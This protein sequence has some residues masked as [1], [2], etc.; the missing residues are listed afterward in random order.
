MI[1]MLK[2]RIIAIGRL[3]SKPIGELAG[4]Y[5]SRLT[6]YFPLERI[7]VKDEAAALKMIEDVDR[8]VVCDE[9]GQQRT[10]VELANWLATYERRRTKRLV[11]F[12]GG[13]EG[14]GP[15]VKKRADSLLALSK[16]TFPHEMSQAIL[17]EQL[18]RAATILKGEAYHK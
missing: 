13:P 14:V 4:D 2:I 11:F 3:K 17:L 10:S 6:H 9:R 1:F 18:Y 8:L 5:A 12:I 16:M 15:G 7:D